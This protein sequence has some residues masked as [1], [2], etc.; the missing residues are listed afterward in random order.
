[1]N[2]V[3]L[4]LCNI[5]ESFKLFC[6]LPPAG[7]LDLGDAVEPG[8]I[9]S[10]ATC[11]CTSCA[12][13]I[14]LQTCI[15]IPKISSFKLMKDNFLTDD[16]EPNKPNKPIEPNKPNKPNKPT[17]GDSGRSPA[18]S[19]SLTFDLLLILTLLTT[20]PGGEGFDLGD[21]L[22]PGKT[23]SDVKLEAEHLGDLH[24]DLL[25]YFIDP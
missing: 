4:C 25:M 1:M 7:G 19:V 13:Y 10:T 8:K 16:P 2:K 23:V 14:L 11:Y 17:S 20:V 9:H 21:A 6:S 18:L 22:G 5:S 3:N 15:L 24:I 12:L